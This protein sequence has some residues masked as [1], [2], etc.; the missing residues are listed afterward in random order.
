MNQDIVSWKKLLIELG[1]EL[2]PND[3]FG[4]KT[5]QASMA[6]A[7]I[8]KKDQEKDQEGDSNV[9]APWIKEGKKVLGLH[10]VYD[11]TKLQ[12]WLKS[13]GHALGDPTKFPWCG[14]YVETC[15]RNSLPNEP[16]EGLVGQNPYFAKNWAQFGIAIDPT[17][18]CILVFTRDG[19]GHV[20]FCMGEDLVG[21]NYFVLGGNQGNKVSVVPVSKKNCIA[22]RWPKTYPTSKINLPR[23]ENIGKVYSDNDF[24]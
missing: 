12:A 2:T 21:Q 3:T 20:G 11:K 16:F 10:E 22:S 6:A 24:A 18:Y 23:Y 5:L 7:G 17:L 1:H 19:G 8:L 15:I 13:D 4:P 14:D 9:E